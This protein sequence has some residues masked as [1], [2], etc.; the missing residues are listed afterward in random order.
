MFQAVLHS[1]LLLEK[2][3]EGKMSF[4][5]TGHWLQSRHRVRLELGGCA[6]P[7][8]EEAWPSSGSTL[9]CYVTLDHTPTSLC[10]SAGAMCSWRLGGFIKFLLGKG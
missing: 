7:G 6:M 3:L 5:F 2:E 4:G 1:Q 9:V 10:S 8:R